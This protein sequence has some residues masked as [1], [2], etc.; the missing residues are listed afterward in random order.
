MTS[1]LVGPALPPSPFQT[2]NEALAMA[3]ASPTGLR[4]VDV[5]EQEQF[6]GWAEL[7]SRARRINDGRGTR[8]G[9]G[10]P[11]SG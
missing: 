11:H 6:L 10:E 5:R 8:F 9:R 4:L 1:S 7:R 3:Q 2:V